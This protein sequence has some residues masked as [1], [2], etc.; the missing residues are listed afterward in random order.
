MLNWESNQVFD[1]I[2]TY[3][4]IDNTLRS[5]AMGHSWGEFEGY[6][7]SWV[8]DNTHTTGLAAIF[9]HNSVSYLDYALIV[10]EL[11]REWGID[12]DGSEM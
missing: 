8:E 2:R 10:Q 12:S 9:A 11:Y 6:L 7:R 4:S 3:P 5:K 1:F